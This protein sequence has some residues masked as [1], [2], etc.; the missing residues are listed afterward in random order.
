MSVCEN[1]KKPLEVEIDPDEDEDVQMGGS[2]GKAPA[3]A[4]ETYTDD[5]QLSCGC[6]F[7][8]YVKVSK[9]ISYKTFSG[10]ETYLTCR[11][12]LLEAYQVT[13][14]SNS[15]IVIVKEY[16]LLCSSMYTNG[17]NWRSQ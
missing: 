11:D 13:E 5:V 12:C 14:C 9:R 15:R 7:H 3:A 8:W 1:C 16:V 6:H 17:S 4:P 10:T 2:S